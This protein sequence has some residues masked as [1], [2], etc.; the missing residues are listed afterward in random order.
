MY[1]IHMPH[2]S[3]KEEKGSGCGPPEQWKWSV[4]KSLPITGFFSRK[5]VRDKGS[6]KSYGQAESRLWTS[7]NFSVVWID[8]I[9]EISTAYLEDCQSPM[10][11]VAR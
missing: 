2:M 3:E 1:I 5:L 6:C 8:G 11:S 10:Y 7:S 4:D 9:H